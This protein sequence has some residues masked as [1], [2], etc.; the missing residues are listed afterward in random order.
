VHYEYAKIHRRLTEDSGS[1]THCQQRLIG[2]ALTVI[3]WPNHC[4]VVTFISKRKTG[5][6]I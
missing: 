4:S 3:N 1:V 5:L 2:V 6:M